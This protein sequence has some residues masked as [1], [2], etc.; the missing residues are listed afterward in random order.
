MHSEQAFFQKASVDF[1]RLAA[2]G[3]CR[4]DD[5]YHYSQP[6]LNNEFRVDIQISPQG[7]VFGR[8]FD[9][10]TESEYAN[11]HIRHQQ[12]EFVHK[13]RT[14][15]FEVLEQILQHCCT[16]RHFTA[17]QA[18]RM[19]DYIL[20][21]FADRPVFP[22]EKYPDFGVFKHR[23]NDKW[24]ALVMQVDK[25]KL[26][27]KSQGKINVINLKVEPANLA[28]LLQQ[29]GIYPAYHMNKKHWIS[30]ILDETVSDTRLIEL[31][32]QSFALTDSAVKTKA[33]TQRISTWLVPANLRYFDVE[34]A[35]R[36]QTEI[37]W[38]QS[39]EV[40]VGDIVYMYVAAP[41]SAI[42]YKCKV[43]EVNLP[44]HK[45]N[46]YV[47][48]DRLM[49]IRLLNQYTPDTL[50]LATMKSLGVGAVRGPR[51]M[52]QVLIDYLDQHE[53]KQKVR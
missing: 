20:A 35:F 29:E 44:Y 34:Q 27:A 3:F 37:G 24:Y 10:G 9:L 30:I 21:N 11:V 13:V 8:V 31:I 46:K 50:P 23:A 2:Y 40:M 43:L 33:R 14:A 5:G 51:G 49:K 26:V 42:L 47:K 45:R 36:E 16:Q 52:P 28:P 12:G 53:N 32:R 48:V 41:R 18:N 38:K 15:Y 7:E 17:A 39:T 25:S 4:Q 22:W 6:I 19:A 1:S